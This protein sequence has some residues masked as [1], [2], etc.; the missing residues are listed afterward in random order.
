MHTHK[1]LVSW[2]RIAEFAVAFSV[3]FFITLALI[4]Y[5]GTAQVSHRPVA[6][7]YQYGP[8]PVPLH[9]AASSIPNDL[10]VDPTTVASGAPRLTLMEADVEPTLYRRRTV[11]NEKFMRFTF[12]V[13]FRGE[14]YAFEEPMTVLVEAPA[15]LN[16]R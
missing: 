4:P 9:E 16:G 1:P 3:S 6:Q 7:G 14:N 5:Q 15:L 10:E 13:E 8:L 12:N 11:K 2:I